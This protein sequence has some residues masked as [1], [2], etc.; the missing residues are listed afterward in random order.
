MKL[1]SFSRSVSA[2][3][4]VFLLPAVAQATS[5]TLPNPQTSAVLYGDFYSYSLPVLAWQNNKMNG[6]GA[7]PGTPYYVDSSPG[8]IQNDV[9]VATGSNGQQVTTNYAG[10]ND[11]YQ[12]PNGTGGLPYFSTGQTGLHPTGTGGLT[13][14]ADQQTTWNATL[15]AMTGF[16]GSGSGSALNSLVFMFNNNE[17]NSGRGANQSLVAWAQVSLRDTDGNAPTKYF[18]FANNCP[19]G[20]LCI[21][22]GVVGATGGI[23]AGPDKDPTLYSRGAPNDS[24][25]VGPVGTNPGLADFVVSG[26]QV[27]LNA[28]GAVVACGTPGAVATI[29]HNLGANQ[30]A[31]AVFSTELDQELSKWWNNGT[32][33]G[34]AYDV[35]SVDFRIGCRSITGFVACANDQQIDGG[36]EQLF[37]ARGLSNTPNRVPAPHVLALFGIGLI[38]LVMLR[39]QARF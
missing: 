1:F 39:K 13:G 18:T 32:G 5:I 29:N 7:G 23:L 6:G 19:T 12:T 15:S 31:Y 30:A 2:T 28:S 25:P 24:Y 4:L 38:S 20:N 37:I 10:M 9:V 26:G 17:M 34:S 22:G 14:A 36:Y 35:M 16:L 27:C 33:N 11:A 8:Q 3:L 21:S